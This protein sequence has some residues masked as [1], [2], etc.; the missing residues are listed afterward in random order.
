[1]AYRFHIRCVEADGGDITAMTE[2]PSSREVEYGELAMNVPEE[3][4]RTA[5]PT[6]DWDDP[7]EELTLESDWAVSYWQSVY[8]GEPCYYV[9]H[10]AI[11]H[12]F[13]E[14]GND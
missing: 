3:E 13:L 2:D 9:V 10:S 14:A 4:L 1:M 7:A 8:R 5:F 6:Y 12:V 11:E